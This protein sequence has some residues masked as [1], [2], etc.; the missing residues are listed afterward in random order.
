MSVSQGLFPFDLE[1]TKKR[2]FVTAHAG[3]AVVY[4]AM[5]AVIAPSRYREL[6]DALGYR[7]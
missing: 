1:L 5:L 7:S 2:D 6:R 3:L 4:E